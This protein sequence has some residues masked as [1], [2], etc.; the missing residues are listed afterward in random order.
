MMPQMQ[1]AAPVF[2]SAVVPAEVPQRFASPVS[3]VSFPPPA[4]AMSNTVSPVYQPQE[5]HDPHWQGR[6]EL[7]GQS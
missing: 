5:L 4:E 3:Q 1:Q 7:Q 6:H 2:T